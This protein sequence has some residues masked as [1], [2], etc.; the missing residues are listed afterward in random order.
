MER[1]SAGMANGPTKTY[2]SDRIGKLVDCSIKYIEKDG[3]YTEK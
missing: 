1:N 3:N 2:Y